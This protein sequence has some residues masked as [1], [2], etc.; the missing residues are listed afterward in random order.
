MF[1]IRS[2]KLLFINPPSYIGLLI[3]NPKLTDV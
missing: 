3:K 1:G 2:K